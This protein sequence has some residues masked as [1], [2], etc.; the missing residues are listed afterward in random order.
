MVLC[1]EEVVT[2]IDESDPVTVGKASAI[3]E[4]ALS[5]AGTVLSKGSKVSRG[6]KASCS[7]IRSSFKSWERIGCDAR[8]ERIAF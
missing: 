1:E 5:S 7:P 6:E 3:R 2:F 4:S 8:G